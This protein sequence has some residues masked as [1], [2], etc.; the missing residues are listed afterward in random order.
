MRMNF[1]CNFISEA[2]LKSPWEGIFSPWASNLT[3]K[4]VFLSPKGSN[5]HY[6]PTRWYW[7]GMK[8]QEGKWTLYDRLALPWEWTMIFF[9]NLHT[10]SFPLPPFMT[11]YQTGR[12]WFSFPILMTSAQGSF[13]I[14]SFPIIMT[15]FK[16]EKSR[17]VTIY[18]NNYVR[19]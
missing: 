13:M 17:K 11:N 5:F 15:S 12:E 1:K 14:N 8:I 19:Y 18:I 3:P 9:T 10:N 6:H 4:L 7:M 2:P 16:R